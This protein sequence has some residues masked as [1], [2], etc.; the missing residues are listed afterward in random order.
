MYTSE[1]IC[2]TLV[3]Y[4]SIIYL[5][6][7]RTRTYQHKMF[8]CMLFLTYVHIIAELVMAD[9]LFFMDEIIMDIPNEM[10]EIHPR[11]NWSNA[12]YFLSMFS[13]YYVTFLY[14]R[15]LATGQD[16]KVMRKNLWS[17]VPLVITLILLFAVPFFAQRSMNFTAVWKFGNSLVPI[18]SI[19]Y[20]IASTIIIYKYHKQIENKKLRVAITVLTV[21]GCLGYFA[22]FLMYKAA[23]DGLR[24]LPY[25]TFMFHDMVNILSEVG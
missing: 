9:H 25:Q 19:L 8:L 6:A 12:T 10:V 4:L 24:I 17:G 3:V 5:G 14:V 1:I 11:T 13:F 7:K 18:L 23:A 22:T 2:L 16:F 15:Y 20:A 21:I